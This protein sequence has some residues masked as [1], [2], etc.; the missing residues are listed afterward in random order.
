M[1]VLAKKK[2]A[3]LTA[4]IIPRGY[5][6]SLDPEASFNFQCNA[7]GADSLQ[8]ILDGE[9]ASTQDFRNRGISESDVVTDEATRSKRRNLSIMRNIHNT[10]IN[11]ITCLAS[12][13]TPVSIVS[14]EPVVFKIQG[15]LDA[16]SNLM[17]SEADNQHIRRLSWDNPFSLDITDID[18]DISH[19]NICYSLINANKFQCVLVNQTEFIFLNINIPLL[20]TVSAVN[21]VG[22]GNASSV[23]GNGCT[24]STG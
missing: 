2:Y 1:I 22:E 9:I 10:N 11:N 20:F 21:V 16:P 18:P 13:F 24:N 8:W 4:V 6:A 7:T 5:N 14:S 17:L 3:Q 15:L 12:S 23:N 19:Y